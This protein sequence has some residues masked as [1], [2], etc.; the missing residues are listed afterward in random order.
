MSGLRAEWA[1]GLRVATGHRTLRVVLI[2]LAVTCVGE[3]IMGTLFA[4]FVRSVLH[5]TGPDY[6]FIMSAQAV[7]GIGGG[8]IA[9][10]LGRRARPALLFG[11]GA[12]AFGAVDLA[13]FLYPLGYVAV[14][15]AVVCMVVVGVPGALTLAGGFTLLQRATAD[16]HRGRVFGVLGAVE[17]V[18]T[19]AGTVTAGFL[20]QAVGIIPV[21]AAQGAGYLIAGVAVV[22]ILRPGAGEPAPAAAGVR[23]ARASI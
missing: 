4:P 2:F 6:G 21:L 10:A 8:L 3:G 23:A 18:A 14:W 7:G 9:A 20:G 15:P 16:S 17:G 5:G 11:W 19:V 13:L 22:L 12:V 1:E